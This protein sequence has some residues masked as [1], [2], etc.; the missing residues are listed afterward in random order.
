MP[1]QMTQNLRFAVGRA[2]D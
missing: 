1:V 2:G